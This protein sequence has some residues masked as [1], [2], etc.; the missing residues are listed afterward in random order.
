MSQKRTFFPENDIKSTPP[1]YDI[2]GTSPKPTYSS[3]YCIAKMSLSE[4]EFIV[5]RR[6]WM[7]RLSS[8]EVNS[9]YGIR[10]WKLKLLITKHFG[11]PQVCQQFFI[12]TF[13]LRSPTSTYCT[14]L[15]ST[16]GYSISTVWVSLSGRHEAPRSKRTWLHRYCTLRKCVSKWKC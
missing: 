9:A 12:A 6:K 4:N 10:S 8:L 16:L 3:Q 2:R 14:L 7:R 13:S 11:T 15:Y 5:L 1:E